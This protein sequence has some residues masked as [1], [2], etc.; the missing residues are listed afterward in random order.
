MIRQEHRE[1]GK[2]MNEVKLDKKAWEQGYQAPRRAICPYEPGTDKALSWASG[3]V[4]GLAQKYA[5]RRSGQGDT[6][7]GTPP[8][9]NLETTEDSGTTI[10]AVE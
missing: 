3:H 1:R 9:R 6:L 7:P 8:D 2:A 10:E 4:E 5:G